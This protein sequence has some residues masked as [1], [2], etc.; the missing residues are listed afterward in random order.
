M[1][2]VIVYIPQNDYNFRGFN[3]GVNYFFF[4]VFAVSGFSL[5]LCVT[6]YPDFDGGSPVTECELLVKG[7]RGEMGDGDGDGERPLEHTAYRG[8]D[9]ECVVTALLPGHNYL[10]LLRA[11]NRVGVRN[12]KL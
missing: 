6:D 10:F 3:E 4:L 8:K 2:S 1:I 12:H 9:L 11:S 5:V 7:K